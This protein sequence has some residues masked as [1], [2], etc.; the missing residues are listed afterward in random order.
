MTDKFVIYVDTREPEGIFKKL[1]EFEEVQPVWQKLDAGDYYI[2]GEKFSLII[3]R[4]TVTDYINSVFDTRLWE[5]LEKIKSA[6][7]NEEVKLIPMLLIEGNWSFILKYGKKNDKSAMGSVYAS[8]LST[9][10]SWGF[11]VVSS[12][13]KSWTPYILV[14]F[15]RWMGRPRRSEPPIFK[16]RALTLDEM[17]IRVLCAFPHISVERAKRILKHYGTLKD[18][19]DN[20]G[21]WKHSIEGIGEKIVSDVKAVLNHKVEIKEVKK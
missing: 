16:P 8:L 9:I 17:A 1:Q 19:L 2:P 15:T 4:K 11:Q 18:A 13:S 10:A 3:E 7:T 5:E 6:E 21:W 12:P 20:V 14:S